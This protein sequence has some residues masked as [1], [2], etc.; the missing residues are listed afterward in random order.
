MKTRYESLSI[1]I[2]TGLFMKIEWL[3]DCIG[4]WLVMEMGIQHMGCFMVSIGVGN[5][6]I[7]VGIVVVVGY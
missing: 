7:D 6:V 4:S 2:N 5:D 3:N 1:Y